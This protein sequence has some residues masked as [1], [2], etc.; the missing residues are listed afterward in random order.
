M[1]VGLPGWRGLANAVLEECRRRQQN[2]FT[3]IQRYYRERNYLDQFDEVEL[4]YGR[5]FLHAVCSREIS[6]PG[7]EGAIY[8]EIS[9]LGFLSYFTTNYDD[10]LLR[11]L[12]SLGK[13]VAVHGNSREDLETVDVDMTPAVVKL[14][15]DFSEPDS[16]VLSRKDYQRQYL[17]GQGESFRR[18]LR[19]SLARDR[20][21]FLGY[22]L[23]DP[24]ILHIQEELAVNLKRKVAPI[25]IMADFAEDDIE[26]WKRRYNIDVVTYS[27]R[28]GN[29]SRLASMLKSVADVI[30]IGSFAEKRTSDEDLR[31]AQALYMWYRFSPLNAGD[32]S[33]DV[34][35]SLIMTALFNSGGHITPSLLAANVSEG[36]GA[37]ISPN[38]DDFVD[39]VSRLMSADWVTQEDGTLN[40]LPEGKRLVER[41]E[42]QF[43]NLMG[44]FRRQ[45]YLDLKLAYNV[46]EGDAQHFSQ[47]V[48]DALIDLFELRGQNIMEMVFDDKPIDPRGI[49]DVL[50]T[51]WRRANTLDGDDARSS[52][53]GFMLNKL[54][55]PTGVYENVLNYLAKSFFC[56]QAMRLDPAVPEFVA[57]VISD[58]TLLIDENILIPLTARHEDRHEFVS[59]V[60]NKA[61]DAN[62][63]LCT[64]QRFV[65]SV[66][67]HADWALAQVLEYGTQSAEVL[68]A[69]R[70]EGDYLPNAF[71][72]GYIAE[73]PDDPNRDFLQYLRDCFGGSYARE[74][75]DRFFGDELGIQILDVSQMAGFEQS[76]SDQYA[77][78][79]RLLNEWNESRSEDTKK[80]V[81]RIES[82]IEAILLIAN[83]S[84]AQISI[85][86][87]TGSR[88]SF[89]SSGSSVA[90][91]A[92][93]MQV[94]PKSMM[95]ASTE[96]IWELLSQSDLSREQA[97]NF[98]SMMLASHFRMAGYFVQTENYQRFFR[99]L[100]SN[101]KKEFEE[102][103][104]LL[105]DALG[106]ELGD[107]FL[108][109]FNDEDLPNV[110]T[111]LQL[112]AVHKATE[113]SHGQQRLLEEN[114]R[115]RT[116]IDDYQ[117]R[118]RRRREFV[119][120][121]R[122]D[123]QPR[124]R[125]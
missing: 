125:R 45:L 100:I 59:Q 30:S 87:L 121:Q 119:A 43:I 118:E 116:M 67:R 83:W 15:G 33:I 60:I 4:K 70:G 57:R 78:A 25:A 18:F 54:A 73:D 120:R 31:Q 101:A 3:R 10:V 64:T 77:E 69:A 19:G 76:K 75:F 56:I 16:I 81:R 28:A 105:E 107:R 27:T 29:H 9:K 34:L 17:S 12:E 1:E 21:L 49:T 106:T 11:H 86:E 93:W 8:I 88:V 47:V 84:D 72:K 92:R 65:D 74:A 36:I 55:N 113:R 108:E 109:D 13:A 37:P 71:L 26:L 61:R 38:N 104:E 66:R 39:A 53:V 24:E 62:I 97:P 89:V 80:S 22:S 2:N 96:A 90:R 50:Q 20:I 46:D 99:P 102:T 122:R 42:R 51:L 110:L 98:R 63:S 40:I 41:Y 115:L 14:H 58:R 123:Q 6:D 95:V 79:S 94:E 112:E 82:E 117:G 32:A 44:V 23:N 85:P 5:D 114:E 103:R 111:S 52:L 124:A 91:L 7:S 35:Q 48:L 68:R